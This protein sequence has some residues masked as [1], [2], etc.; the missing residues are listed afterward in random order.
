MSQLV[1]EKMIS[2]GGK[3]FKIRYN[4]KTMMNFEKK[5]NVKFFTFL[6]SLIPKDKDDNPIERTS[7]EELTILVH[8]FLL[9]GG[10]TVTLDE[11]S[12]MLDLEG[13]NSFLLAI[14]EMVKSKNTGEQKQGGKEGAD[15]LV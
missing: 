12:E 10:N 14:P 4:F 2:L 5:C 1:K 6:K 13:F 15:P 7:I 8:S 11:V 3:E 9:G